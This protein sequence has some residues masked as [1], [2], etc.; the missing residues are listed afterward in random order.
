[1]SLYRGDQ[2]LHLQVPFAGGLHGIAAVLDTAAGQFFLLF[3]G[4]NCS[5]VFTD[6]RRK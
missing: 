6:I 2:S 5:L 1:M 3:L 4:R